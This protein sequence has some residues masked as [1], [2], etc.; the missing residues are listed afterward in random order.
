MDHNGKWVLDALWLA[1]DV[2]SFIKQPSL[3]GALWIAAD[4]VSFADP[5]G[6]VSTMAHAGKIA[7]GIAK[8]S[9]IANKTEDI[10]HQASVIKGTSKACNCF[11]AGTKVFTDEGEKPIKEIRVGDKV[12]ARDDETGEMAYKEVEW[13]FQRDVEETYNIQLVAKSLRQPMSI[14]SGLLARVG[15]NHNT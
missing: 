14:R 2:V 1:V 4:I 3:A 13:L 12:L 9:K 5:T 8:A 10:V 7:K 6:T 11:T 15:W